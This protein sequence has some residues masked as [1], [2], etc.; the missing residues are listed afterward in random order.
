MLAQLI[1]ADPVLAS[2]LGCA[3]G[4]PQFVSGAAQVFQGGTM[5]YVAVSP[6]FIYSLT[7]D[8]RFR[9]FADTWIEGVDPNSGGEIPPPGLIEPIR[10]FGK[11]WRLNPDVRAGLGWAVTGELGGVV[12]LQSFERGRAIFLPDRGETILMMDNPDGQSGVWR[13]FSGGF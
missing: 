2:Q 11:V 12:T 1:G 13:A 10:G 7:A 5:Y 3:V 9:R 6:A 4:I 8:S